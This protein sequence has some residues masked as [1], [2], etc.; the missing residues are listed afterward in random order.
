MFES[1]SEIQSKV[2]IEPEVKFKSKVKSAAE[3]L[4]EFQEFYKDETSFEVKEEEEANYEAEIGLKVKEE[5][6]EGDELKEEEKFEEEEFEEEESARPAP[7]LVRPHIGPPD[8]LDL[9]EGLED[10][11]SEAEQR[12]GELEEKNNVNELRLADLDEHIVKLKEAAEARFAE[13]EERL[14]AM[15]SQLV[16]ALATISSLQQVTPCLSPPPSPPPSPSLT[17]PTKSP[18]L[19]SLAS[20]PI[21]PPTTPVPRRQHPAPTPA[22]TLAM[23]LQAATCALA[24]LQ[25]IVRRCTEVVR[26]PPAPCRHHLARRC[27]YGPGGQGCRYGHGSGAAWRRAPPPPPSSPSPSSSATATPRAAPRRPGASTMIPA[28]SHSKSHPPEPCY[29]VSPRVAA[30]PKSCERF[31]DTLEELADN[32]LDSAAAYNQIKSK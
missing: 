24:D 22:L 30:S 17:T 21:T 26:R 8:P 23:E 16:A 20:L 32:V 5:V 10:A 19:P 11:L 14:A 9:C 2:K 4:K 15:S 27:W 29:T 7:P 6:F 1:Q 18:N 13:Q 28:K 31:K 3:Y 25:V 12:I